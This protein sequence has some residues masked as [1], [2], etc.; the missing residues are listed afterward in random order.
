[1]EE[2]IRKVANDTVNKTRD[3]TE[4]MKNATSDKM[5][6]FMENIENKA[7]SI[8]KNRSPVKRV[9]LTR[10]LMHGR[11]MSRIKLIV[12]KGILRSVEWG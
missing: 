11:R 6:H 3:V 7:E 2:K 4:R 1:M 5:K 8:K 10:G 12:Q 9:I